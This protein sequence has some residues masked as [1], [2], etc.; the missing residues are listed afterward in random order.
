MHKEMF[1]VLYVSYIFNHH[2]KRIVL[3]PRKR[4]TEGCTTVDRE[5]LYLF[6]DMILKDFSKDL[7]FESAIKGWINFCWQRRG[8]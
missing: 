3:E 2:S 4:Q 6:K 5:K 1:Q 7:T 8:R